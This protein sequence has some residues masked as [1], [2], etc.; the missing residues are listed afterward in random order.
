VY[1]EALK[2]YAIVEWRVAEA[3]GSS[4]AGTITPPSF[5]HYFATVVLYASGNLKVA[6]A[7][8]R[9]SSITTTTLYALLAD[10]MLDRAR[11]ETF[12]KE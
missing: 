5:R 8:A 11:F 3:L 6:Q 9:H 2:A 1:A 10:D 7:M 12:E 4:D